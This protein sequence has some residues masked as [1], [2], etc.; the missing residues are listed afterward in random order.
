[1]VAGDKI[2]YQKYQPYAYKAM[3]HKFY[4]S[5]LDNRKRRKT[6]LKRF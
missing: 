6:V 5:S 2:M 3:H 4:Q 1:M